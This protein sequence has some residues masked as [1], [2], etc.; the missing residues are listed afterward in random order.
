MKME[1]I[2]D[3]YG[4]ECISE[5]IAY[6][7][8]VTTVSTPLIDFMQPSLL[9]QHNIIV[10]LLLQNNIIIII[11]NWDMMDRSPMYD[12]DNLLLLPGVM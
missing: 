2:R 10:A 1:I 9:L 7:A 4:A 12:N 3:H 11:T 8:L 6:Y 5:Q